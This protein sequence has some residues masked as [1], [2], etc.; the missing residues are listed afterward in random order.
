MVRYF[1]RA[2]SIK[3]DTPNPAGECISRK[4]SVDK[5]KLKNT[6]TAPNAMRTA[7]KPIDPV[8]TT[9]ANEKNWIPKSSVHIL[10]ARLQRYSIADLGR[11][12]GPNR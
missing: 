7:Y 12:S 8:S 10:G 2:V 3:E 9:M 4:I 6:N 11:N 1:G 5:A